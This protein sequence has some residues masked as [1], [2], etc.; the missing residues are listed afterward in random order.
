MNRLFRG[1]NTSIRIFTPTDSLPYDGPVTHQEILDE[2]K[3]QMARTY[4]T[5]DQIEK[6][7]NNIWSYKH[8][9]LY[10]FVQRKIDVQLYEFFTMVWKS[11]YK[12]RRIRKQEKIHFKIM[13]DNWRRKEKRIFHPDYIS[14]QKFSIKRQK[15]KW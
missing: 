14:K 8:R 10:W 11:K 9:G 5:D 3:R 15:N 7:A 12:D 13:K 1:L 6:I 2:I 4:V